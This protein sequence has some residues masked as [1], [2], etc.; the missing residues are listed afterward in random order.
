MA[1]ECRLPSCQIRQTGSCAEGHSPP[2]SCPNFGSLG[3]DELDVYKDVADAG[4]GGTSSDDET[5]VPLPTGE[6][7]DSAEVDRF[8][9]WRPATFIT[10]VG[11][12]DSGKSTLICALYDRLLHGPFANLTF[13]GSRTL[14]AFERRLHYSRVDSGR[15]APDAPRTSLS[16]GLHYFHLAVVPASEQP[17]RRDLLV[18]DRAGEVYRQARGNSMLIASLPEVARADRLVLLLDGRRVGDA[19]ER[20]NALQSVRQTLRAFLDNEAS[21]RTSIVQVVTTKFDLIFALEDSAQVE[22]ALGRFQVQ[23]TRDFAS[24][25]RELTFW[26]IAARD[27]TGGYAPAYGLD[28]MLVDWV[29]PRP[30]L[31]PLSV[32]SLVLETEFDRLLARTPL[33]TG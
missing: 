10:V 31:T 25:L 9:L 28:A 3:A 12:R 21:G 32:T 16:E 18:S 20:A 27:P 11:D 30:R 1:I 7:L 4:I 6:A 14:V 15:A 33:E 17:I 19:P 8:L 5:R 26:R 24:R 23:L 22:D 2:D 13:A 29:S